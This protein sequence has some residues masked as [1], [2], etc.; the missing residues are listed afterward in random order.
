MIRL[1]GRTYVYQ[2]MRITGAADPTVSVKDTLEGK[3]PQKKIVQVPQQR[4]TVPTVTRLVWQPVM[5]RKYIIRTMWQNVWRSVRFW[6]QLRDSA[7]QRLTS[8][9]GDIIILLGGR[10]GRDGCRW[11]NRFF[12]GT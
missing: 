4:V 11:S 12:Q 9:P 5:S 7:V 8:D 3:L 6:V 2:A 10:T 1:S